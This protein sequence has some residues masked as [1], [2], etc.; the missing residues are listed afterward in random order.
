MLFKDVI[1]QKSIKEHLISMF[2]EDR[3]SHAQLFTGPEGA[4]LIP[5]ALAFAQYVNCQNPGP[6]DSCGVCPE[7]KKMSRL[8][9]PDL[10]FVFPVINKG[11]HTPSVCNDFLSQWRQFVAQSPYFTKHEWSSFLNAERGQVRIFSREGNE[12]IKKLSFKAF[13]AKYKIMIIWQPEKMGKEAANR[14]LKILEEPPA[15]TLFLLISD[16]PA[17]ILPTILSRTQQLKIPKIDDESMVHALQETFQIPE[18][19]AKSVA[20]ISRGNFVE[21][22][23]II[24]NSEEKQLFHSLFVS[25]MRNAYSG[26]LAAINE[27]VDKVALLPKEQLK[28]LLE[29]SIR[30]LRE[31]YIA[32][33]NIPELVYAT[34]S[35]NKFIENFKSFVN[36]RNVE[37]MVKEYEL[38]LA[39]I[40]Q[41][42]NNKLVLFD[43]SMQISGLFRVTNNL[44]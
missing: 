27:W 7:C 17:G 38:A 6:E 26:N 10:H 36:D 25:A 8:V 23:N 15:R 19:E 28:N 3:I 13:E 11:G 30:I 37:Q 21:A 39:H 1:G 2:R 9:H 41:N 24:K 33:F 22:R 34:P 14:L 29:Y 31:S 40:E 5:L 12:I 16:Y 35:E 32:N 4:G 43:M 20:R 18:E 42:G 44:V